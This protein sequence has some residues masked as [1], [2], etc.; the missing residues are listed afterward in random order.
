MVGQDHAE[1]C[2]G[3]DCH[4]SG[5]AADIGLDGRGRIVRLEVGERVNA[6]Q[7][8]DA[9]NQRDHCESEGIEP[10]VEADPETADPAEGFGDRFAVE[11]PCGL[12]DRPDDR[13]QRSGSSHC[14]RCTTQLLSGR[15]DADAD[16]EMEGEQGEHR[17]RRRQRRTWRRYYVSIDLQW[18]LAAVPLEAASPS[19][20]R[21]RSGR[22]CR[23][24]ATWFR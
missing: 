5:Q 16:D 10:Q 17:C 22:P 15:D 7:K 8:S 19:G 23:D 9:R 1:H 4:R 18:L 13:G 21:V 11:H 12:C 3:K 14:K 6:D 20:G 2:T 24:G